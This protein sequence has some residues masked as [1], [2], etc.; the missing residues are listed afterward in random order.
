MYPKSWESVK[1][2]SSLTNIFK[3]LPNCYFNPLIF[4][5]CPESGQGGLLLGT[6]IKFKKAD[7]LFQLVSEI[8]SLAEKKHGIKE[9]RFHWT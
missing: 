5:L 9:H 8:F 7:C 1:Q 2:I 4:S 3:T 6:V